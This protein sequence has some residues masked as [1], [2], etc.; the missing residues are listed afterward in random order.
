MAEVHWTDVEIDLLHNEPPGLFPENQDSLWGQMRKIF[1]DYMQEQMV[2]LISAWYNNMD[3]RT[4]DANDIDKWEYMVGLP[5]G[6]GLTLSQRRA[7]V[8]A[9]LV[10]GPFTNKRRVDI[11]E[12][13]LQA[14]LGP[15]T[16]FTS[17]GIPLT[18]SG[19]PLY[20]GATSLVGLYTITEDVENFS[21]TVQVNAAIDTVSLRRALSRVT[22]AGI[23]INIISQPT[24]GATYSK[25]GGARSSLQGGGNKNVTTTQATR[26]A[27]ITQANLTTP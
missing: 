18:A 20:S 7:N 17:S 16:E 22:P 2:D 8:Q 10:Y 5:P 1:A 13:V 14:S 15:A 9:R 4:V 26:R 19:I 24:T 6:T 12:S 3:P 25:T 27:V 11:I 21:Y 23:N